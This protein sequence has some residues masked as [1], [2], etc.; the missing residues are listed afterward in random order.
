MQNQR[1]RAWIAP[2][3]LSLSAAILLRVLETVAWVY[4]LINVFLIGLPL[5]YLFHIGHGFAA[6]TAIGASIALIYLSE[7]TEV[8]DETY[9]KLIDRGKV[10]VRG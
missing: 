2:P 8:L 3:V 10:L 4:F 5:Y 9:E 1:E 7:E 6:M